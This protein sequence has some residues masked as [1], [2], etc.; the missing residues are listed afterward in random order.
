MFTICLSP[1]Q[2]VHYVLSLFYVYILYIYMYRGNQLVA[3]YIY[4]YYNH[5]VRNF[6]QRLTVYVQVQNMDTV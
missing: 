3:I 4:I 1:P 6:L 5:F 2:Y